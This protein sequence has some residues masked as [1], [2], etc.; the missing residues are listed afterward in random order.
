MSILPA[1]EGGVYLRTYLAPLSPWLERPDITD[2]L[3]NRPGEVWIES[4]GKLTRAEA[5][6]LSALML[7]RL[8]QQIAAVSAQGVN[9]EHP[10]LA[11][12]LPGGARVQV[13]AP[14][15][16]RQHLALAIRK[17]VVDDV[18]LQDM[19]AQGSFAE[20]RRADLDAPEPVDAELSALLAHG[21]IETFLRTA[22]RAGKTI[23]ISGGT[24]TGKTTFL[25]ALLREVPSEERILLIEDT[26][27]VRLHQPNTVGMVAV[28]G[29]LGEAKVGVDELMQAAL[30]MRPD[31][32]MVGEIRG[33]EAF[34][35]LRAVNTGHPGSMTTVHADSPR[36]ALDQIAFMALQ[37]GVNLSR[38]EVIAYAREVVD[39]IVQLTRQGGRRKVA[40]IAFGRQVTI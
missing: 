16:T 34:S 6:E 14:P 33:R 3:V 5:P 4:Q 9:R 23:V 25:N 11:A 29:E 39:V 22:V 38:A 10:L 30:R 13:V 32:L 31:R 28:K 1:G 7:Q 8:T 15:A 26:P 24:A 12:T 2:I 17:H 37:A 35:F 20:V 18:S 27:E 19:A 36:G 21:A 40:A